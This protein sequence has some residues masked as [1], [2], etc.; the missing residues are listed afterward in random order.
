MKRFSL[1]ALMLVLTVLPARAD[2][3]SIGAAVMAF[4]SWYATIGVVGQLLVQVGVSLALTAASYGISYL[5]SGGGKRQGQA[6]QDSQ[7]TSI[8][9]FDALLEVGR[10]Y[11]TVTTAGGVFFHQTVASTGSAPDLWVLG[12]ALSEGECD[13]LVSVMFNGVEC[14]FD[15][16]GNATTAP[17]FNGSNVYARASFRTGTAT[18]AV[19][20]IIAARF[21]SPPHGFY[22][23]DGDRLTKW[24]GFYQRG[25]CTL[26]LE[27]AYGN[28]ADQHT[29]LWGV[30]GVPSIL[31]RFKALKLYDRTRD[32]QAAEDASTWEWT[33]TAAVAIEDYIC[34]DIGWQAARSDIDDVAA[35]ESIDIDREVIATLGDS[36][37][38]GRINGIVY[39]TESPVDAISNMAQASR[40][41]ISR[42]AGTYVIRSDRAAAAV[43]TIHAGQWLRD[44]AISMQNEPD[45][46]SAID[47]VV[48]QFYPASRYGQSA[49]TAYPGTALDD[50]NAER[51]TFRFIDSAPA[52]QRLAYAM[53]TE[54]GE[55]RTISG[56]FDIS[57]LAASGKANRLLEIGDVVNWQ[58]AA[59]Y[60]DMDGLYRVDGLSI[61]SNFTVS[62]S[63]S[64]TSAAVINGWSTALETALETPA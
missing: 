5:V 15:E 29:E 40:A 58:G 19:D 25:V 38:R 24:A 9:E 50:P 46:R 44:G 32:A 55:G 48:A 10:A 60:S 56:T 16:D 6:R 30:A 27:M 63:L 7:G 52:A 57:V 31:V 45:T 37:E 26:V 22:P 3:V 62:L 20:P 49:E 33:D 54:N 13:S 61:N 4:G 43:A 28:S 12:L 53:L 47:G 64:G 59:P 18:Q 51:V 14:L 8:P 35:A 2:P 34:A 11:G 17:W 1:A 39:S 42:T 36:E 23:G 41:T 21:A